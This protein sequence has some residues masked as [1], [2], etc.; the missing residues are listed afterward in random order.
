MYSMFPEDVFLLCKLL[1]MDLNTKAPTA[2]INV[3]Q[4]NIVCIITT[5]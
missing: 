1:A 3:T 5:F 4:D 2:V